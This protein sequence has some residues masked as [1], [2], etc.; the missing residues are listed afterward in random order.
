MKKI[1]FLS[2]YG[3]QHHVQFDASIINFY[4]S[5][6][7][8]YDFYFVGNIAHLR[9]V[10]ENLND[11]NI[12][13][14]STKWSRKTWIY[15]FYFYRTFYIK[16]SLRVDLSGNF[17][18]PL[19]FLSAILQNQI[20]LHIPWW[21]Y[22]GMKK[23]FAF[24]NICLVRFIPCIKLVVLGLWI[25]EAY[26]KTCINSKIIYLPHPYLLK[27]CSRILL[28]QSKLFGFL[29]SQKSFHK[30]DDN[31]HLSAV[32]QSYIK[33]Q[34]WSV[35]KDENF[36][37]KSDFFYPSVR[38]TII[39]YLQYYTYTCSG[40]F[41]ESL[42]YRVP[43]ICFKSPMSDYFFSKYWSLWFVCDSVSELENII[44]K[45]LA[46][47]DLALYDIFLKNIE[48]ALKE[49]QNIPYL[50]EVYKHQLFI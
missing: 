45:I 10:C 25:K 47:E 5:I 41:I 26:A 43:I 19:F 36:S 11:P 3:D 38:Y 48:L 33:E 17:F 34:W 14:I 15:F 30:G 42:A 8:G 44:D 50:T 21:Q 9:S 27:S 12:F 40:V 31:L 1:I 28:K 13:L 20:F 24:I 6:Y 16:S 23:F 7:K 2:T 49:V 4:R 39:S 29:W 37:L 46:W 35:L 32:I 22:S 18:S